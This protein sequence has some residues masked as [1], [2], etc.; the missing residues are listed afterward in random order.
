MTLSEQYKATI[1]YMYTRLPMFQRIGSAAYKKDLTNIRALCDFLGQP[2]QQYKTIHVAGTNGKGSVSHMLSAIFQQKG[3]KTGLYVSPHYKDYRER[4]KVNGRYVSKRFVIEFIDKLRPIIE[5]VN[6]SFFEIN[7]AMAFEYFRQQK[8]DMAIIET[9]LGGRLDST[10]IIDPVISV[11]TN[12]SFDHMSMLGNTLP[13]IAVEKAGIIKPDR[14]V[15]IGERQTDVQQVFTQKA[16]ELSCPILFASDH[17]TATTAS[18]D[19][20]H[21]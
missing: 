17:F 12:I 1:D 13:E 9:G 5:Q 21:T 10:N 2:Q 16:D 19:L 14:P 11:I 15:V 3:L 8:V 6:P 18:S 4:I 20:R 7:V